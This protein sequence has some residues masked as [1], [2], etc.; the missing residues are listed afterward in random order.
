MTRLLTFI[1]LTLGFLTEAKGFALAADTDTPSDT[2][3][4]AQLD[5]A[6]KECRFPDIPGFLKKT[7]PYDYDKYPSFWSWDYSRYSHKQAVALWKC[8]EDLFS[9][10]EG[11]QRLPQKTKEY[12]DDNLDNFANVPGSYYKKDGY[13][14]FGACQLHACS[15]NAGEFILDPSK[16]LAAFMLIGYP[17]TSDSSGSPLANELSD[18][19]SNKEPVFFGKKLGK[20]EYPLEV[21]L[22]IRPQSNTPE[23]WKF[24]NYTF[25]D[26]QKFYPDYGKAVI[27]KINDLSDKAAADNTAKASKP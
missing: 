4:E 18:T 27:V 17:I 11:F 2:M 9:K 7:R 16:H 19:L 3:T 20:D 24:I 10:G 13:I 5:A 1:L 23:L 26:M 25:E 8:T 12:L 6:A 22:A 15:D 21:W 14:M